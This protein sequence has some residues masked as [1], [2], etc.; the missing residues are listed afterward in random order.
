MY[1]QSDTLMP[2]DIFMNLRN[3]CL[4]MYELDPAHFRSVPGSSWETALKRSLKTL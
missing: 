4:E 1:V 2:A 3:M